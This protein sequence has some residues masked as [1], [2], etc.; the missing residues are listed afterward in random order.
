MEADEVVLIFK[1]DKD[2]NPGNYSPAS[3]TSMPGKFVEKIIL[4]CFDKHLKENAVMCHS[5][6]GFVR[7]KSGFSNLI[8]FHDKVTHLV[9]QG[10]TIDVIFWI[11][12]KIL[13]LSLTGSLWTK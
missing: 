9:D 5:Q 3:L 4:K 10:K 6:P 13:V 2:N 1:K 7:G 8:S 12:V 11:S